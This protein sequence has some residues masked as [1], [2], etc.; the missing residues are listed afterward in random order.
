MADH[1]ELVDWDAFA[2]RV[3]TLTQRIAE[4]MARRGEFPTPVRFSPR[5]PPLWR[6]VDVEAWITERLRVGEVAA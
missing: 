3:P 5:T 2:D 6:A 4:R 1:I